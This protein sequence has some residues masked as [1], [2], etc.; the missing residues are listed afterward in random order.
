LAPRAEGVALGDDRR[1]RR[2]AVG[3]RGVGFSARGQRL[4]DGIFR[5]LQPSG[6]FLERSFNPRGGL[7]GRLTLARPFAPALLDAGHAMGSKLRASRGGV[8]PRGGRLA[9]GF[10]GFHGGV[11]HAALGARDSRLQ[12]RDLTLSL[13]RNRRR[14]TRV[15]PGV[16]NLTSR[17]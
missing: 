17:A 12:R 2:G 14:F 4:R 16:V 15:P 5:K 10:D 6:Y 13:G 7:G 3:E 11:R 1:E 8:S 9:P